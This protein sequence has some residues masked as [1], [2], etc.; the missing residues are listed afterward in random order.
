MDV[1]EQ[2]CK[3]LS[4]TPEATIPLVDQYCA[5]YQDLFPDVRTYESFKLLH[6]G[7][8]SNIKRKS[9]PELEKV[10]GIS[11][12]SLHHFL[13]QSPWSLSHLEQRRLN[14]LL[15][16]LQ[17][18]EIILVVDETG[19]RKKGKKTDY[20]ARQYLGNIGKIDN[21]IVSVNVYGIYQ[22]IT[23]PL[24]TKIYK[25]ESKL[26]VED[27][28]Q[29]KTE[30]AGEMVKELKKLGFKIKLVL[31]DS[32]YGESSIFLKVLDEL[33]L[34]YVVSIR[35]NHGVWMPS[36]QRV[37]AN[38]WCKFTRIFSNGETEIRYIREI[39]YG[40]RGMITYW[41][42]TTDTET[43]PVNSTS[44]IMTNCQGNLKK[45]LGNLYGQRT[46][47]EYGFRQC[48]QEL[49]WKDYRLTKIEGIEKW[50]SIINSVY[51][52]VS[53]QTKQFRNLLFSGEEIKEKEEKIEAKD[54]INTWKKSLKKI[55]MMIEPLILFW[56]ITPWLK[57]VNSS[58]LLEGFNN[59]L[60]IAHLNRLYFPSG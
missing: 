7:I 14:K 55:M 18:K 19:D 49:G 45:R 22:N 30:I 51:T 6:L 32:L 34:E 47:V 56:L 59:L 48:K 39:I 2:V 46:W 52:M 37:R 58:L 1:A 54:K 40:K 17:G 21:G 27:K 15:T 16:I 26:K 10:V 35:S 4:R 41:E 11:S 29:T 33:K 60:S 42:M 28:Y 13:S 12:Q 9:L 20:V 23:F 25:P 5:Y 44:F 38:K 3:H 24:M 50:W 57:I 31:A 53:L 36:N 43:L 8:I